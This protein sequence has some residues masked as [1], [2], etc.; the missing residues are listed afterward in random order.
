MFLNP[1]NFRATQM[2][3]TDFS[4]ISFPVIVSLIDKYSSY[5]HVVVIWKKKIIDVDHE[6]L[7]ELAVD[8]VDCL[9]GK[10]NFHK[11]VCGYSIISSKFVKK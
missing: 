10:K 2:L 4:K 3:V 6:Y 1:Q 8:T 9:A 5:N 7:F 11:F